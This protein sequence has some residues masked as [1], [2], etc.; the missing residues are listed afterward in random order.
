VREQK[1]LRSDPRFAAAERQFA[2]LAGF[3]AYCQHLP[4]RLFPLVRR[5]RSVREFR[6]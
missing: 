5:L 4:T 3:L 1:A 2:T 6:L